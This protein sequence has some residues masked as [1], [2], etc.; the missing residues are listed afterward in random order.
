MPLQG[1][2]HSWK[3]FY[4]IIKLLCSTQSVYS[5]AFLDVNFQDLP[6]N[7]YKLW[8]LFNP[9]FEHIACLFYW[10]RRWESAIVSLS[11]CL[12]F[13]LT[14]G[15]LSQQSLSYFESCSCCDCI[16]RLRKSG[17]GITQRKGIWTMIKAIGSRF[18][19]ALYTQGFG[20]GVLG[21][22]ILRMAAFQWTF[23]CLAK[24]PLEFG[25]PITL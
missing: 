17:Y 6:V 12:L 21:I 2:C 25:H 19:S 24:V 7:N 23:I 13:W 3:S 11:F 10:Q 20:A 22:C 9:L 5:C 15:I 4:Q 16:W 18:M 8:S 1:Y 14:F